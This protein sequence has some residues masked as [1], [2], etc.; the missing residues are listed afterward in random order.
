M[1]KQLVLKAI[2]TSCLNCEHFTT[3]TEV[4]E[5]YGMRPPAETIAM[6]CEEWVDYIPF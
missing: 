1:T 2:T 5:K 6:G 4:C 3:P